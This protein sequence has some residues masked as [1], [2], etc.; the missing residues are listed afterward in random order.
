MVEREGEKRLKDTI[1]A[2][3]SE[4]KNELSSDRRQA[5]FGRLCE[6]IYKWCRDYGFKRDI[7]KMGL[8][9]HNVI[10]RILKDEKMLKIPE[11]KDGF[12]SYFKYS[13]ETEKGSYYRQYNENDIIKISKEKKSK[14]RKIEE[15]I[16]A[17]KSLLGRELTSDEEIQVASKWLKKKEYIDLLNSRNVGSI[18]YTPNGGSDEIDGLNRF[19]TVS[20]DPHDIYINKTIMESI[21]DAAK[22]LLDK[23]QKRTRNCYKAL[24][25][26]HCIKKIKGFEML[27]PVLDEEILETWHKTGKKPTQYEI[28]QKYH[29]DAK[30][31]SVEAMASKDLK[32]FLNK[33]K[34]YLEKK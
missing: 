16:K 14:L 5:D 12:F 23:K 20:D 9:I 7:N 17:K 22:F 34:A 21:R 19:L 3:F 30:K 10:C 24:Y 26:L 2:I 25:T 1:F 28:Y 27:Y 13:F 18:S 33:I 29:P 32:G 31:D 11:D 15:L 4:Y 6:Q 8:E